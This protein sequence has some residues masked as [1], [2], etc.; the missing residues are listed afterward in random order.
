MAISSATLQ[1]RVDPSLASAVGRPMGEVKTARA[2]RP[3][4]AVVVKDPAAM[5]ADMAEELG[6]INAEAAGG[7]DETEEEQDA[8]FLQQF[9]E[10]SCE[11]YAGWA[12][13]E[14]DHRAQ[15]A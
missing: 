14:A 2:D 5:M 13:Q 11:A 15:P 10:S 4:E 7:A 8:A 1:P 3:R 6:F 9:F 12:R